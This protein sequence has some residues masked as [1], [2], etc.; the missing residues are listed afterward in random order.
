MEPT[1]DVEV[2]FSIPLNELRKYASEVEITEV[3]DNILKSLIDDFS[4]EIETYKTDIT[5]HR[6]SEG[7]RG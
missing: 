2:M 7:I 4:F 6:V 3:P 5:L 1:L